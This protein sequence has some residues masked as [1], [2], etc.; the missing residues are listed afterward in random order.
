M[1]PIRNHLS[2]AL[3]GA[4]VHVTPRLLS[5]YGEDYLMASKLFTQYNPNALVNRAGSEI[6]KVSAEQAFRRF[7]IL[8]SDAGYYAGAKEKTIEAADDA[9]RLLKEDPHLYFKVLLEVSLGGLAFKQQPTL[10]ALAL[11]ASSPDAATRAMALVYLP[12]IAR[13]STHL[14]TFLNYVD[15]QRGHGSRGMKRA[16]W[17]WYT[18]RKGAAGWVAYQAVKYRQRE[19]WTHRDVLRIARSKLEVPNPELEATLKWIVKGVLTDE[20]PSIIEGY[21]MVQRE[22]ADVPSLVRKYGLTWEMLPTEALTKPE[23]WAALVEK[24]PVGALLRNLPRLTWLGLLKDSDVLGCVNRLTDPK[25][26][27]QGKIHP[28]QIMLASKTYASGKGKGSVWAPDSYV[29]D[30]L[31]EAFYAAYGA[32]ESSGKRELWAIDVSQSMGVQIAE[33][34]DLTAREAACALALVAKAVSPD[35]VDIV[36]F[37]SAGSGAWTHEKK[38]TG[39]GYY[40]GYADLGLTPLD[41]SPKRRLDDIVA[42][43]K[44]LPF[45]GTDCSLPMVYAKRQKLSYDT[46]VVVTDNETWA[47]VATPSAALREYR[48]AMGI[49]ARLVVAGMESSRGTIADPSDP[50]MLDVVGLDSSVPTVINNF[51]AGRV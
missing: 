43:V 11:A 31:A 9:L 35:L 23:V 38:F 8:G 26:L 17:D 51:S 29:S 50:G 39:N 10:F 32:V 45:G 19:G 4:A 33:G 13:T 18:D 6:F 16:L 24:M 34:M 36:G 1:S 48:E 15:G 44:G 49:N 20:T 3:Q 42:G 14:F 41:F 47:H 46:F 27:K 22:N 25:V 7:L 28:I 5:Y 30:V 12:D 40:R 37:T 2:N 21:T